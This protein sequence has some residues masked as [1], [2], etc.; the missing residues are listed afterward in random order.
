M[1]LNSLVAL[2]VILF[3]ITSTS[4]TVFAEENQYQKG[5]FA[6]GDLLVRLRAAYAIYEDG[7]DNIGVAGIANFNNEVVNSQNSFLPELDFTYFL[8]KN[9]AVEA[10]CC[11]AFIR[12]DASG[13]LAQALPGLGLTNGTEVIETYA[14]PFTLLMQY[15]FDEMY[16]FKPYVGVGPTYAV[17]FN[18]E[19]GT[20]LKPIATSVEVDNAWGYT[21]QAGFDKHLGGNW[22]MNFDA[23]YMHLEVDAKWQTPG[24]GNGNIVAEKVRLNPWILSVG[25]GYKF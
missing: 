5:Q 15:H 13:A 18:E 19:V 24:V 17:F 4:K 7:A 11:A 8:S 2:V 10:I 20:A 12:A 25:I 21:L 1:K 14:A 3:T 22:H 16:G 9:L 6:A 23:K